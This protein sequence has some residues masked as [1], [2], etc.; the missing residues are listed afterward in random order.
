MNKSLSHRDIGDT[1]QTITVVGDP[2]VSI[3]VKSDSCGTTSEY[4][5]E[6]AREIEGL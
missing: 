3:T 2:V 4:A 5:A 1:R 6:I